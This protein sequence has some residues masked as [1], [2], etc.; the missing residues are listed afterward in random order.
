MSSRLIVNVP[1]LDLT[2][3]VALLLL[4]LVQFRS[5]LFVLNCYVVHRD[6]IVDVIYFISP[7]FI[8]PLDSFLTD[9][10]LRDLNGVLVKCR[11]TIRIVC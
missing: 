7:L 10:G 5:R 11:W 2:I 6:V 3:I 1:M 4:R 9:H 8:D